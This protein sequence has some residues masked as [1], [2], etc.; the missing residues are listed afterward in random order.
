MSDPIYSTV[1]YVSGGCF[2]VSNAAGDPFAGEFAA[3]VRVWADCRADGIR[4]GTVTAATH[5]AAAGHTLVTVALDAGAALTP[6][7]AAVL[8]G[9]DI[10]ESLCSHAANHALGGRDPLSPASAGLAGLVRLASSAE[11]QAG[12]NA[13]KAVTP[14]GLAS[15]AKGLVSANTMIH[16]ATTGSDVTGTGAVG[17]PFASI[18]QALASIAG[19]LIA[20]GVTVTIKVADG[21]YSLTSAITIDH[22]D[23]DKILIL[24]NTSAETTVA[25]T[26]I[27]SAAR[28]F[29]VAGDYTA[30]IL[31][32]DIVGLAGSS[33]SG[34]NG[35][36]A[37]SG[38]VS[39]SGYT[40]IACAAE[41]IVS[42]TVG[43]G[44]ILIMARNRCRINSS[45]SS[46]FYVSKEIKQI[47]GFDVRSTSVGSLSGI[48]ALATVTLAN[49]ITLYGFL[50]GF[51]ATTAKATLQDVTIKQCT[52]SL[53]SVYNATVLMATSGVYI[54]DNHTIGMYVSAGSILSLG[55]ST[56]I[57]RGAGTSYSP[58]PVGTS[59]NDNS[60]IVA[61]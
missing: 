61:A 37:V 32:G 4:L 27:D 47:S 58:A 33:T 10:P 51:N 15:A 45:G 18:S 28:T 23:A 48:T 20:S 59:G 50:Y 22:P 24:G 3:G 52:L 6:N 9:N 29:T 54:F 49:K 60:V 25:I 19:K 46:A 35:A 40:T 7:L 38:V 43:G 11:A 42:D 1:A 21:T 16:V 8:H 14:A 5:D 57:F 2:A 36:Y 39:S 26:A 30:S 44:S 12:T 31:V 13:E 53:M 34:L 17:A 41:T 55:N 56:Q